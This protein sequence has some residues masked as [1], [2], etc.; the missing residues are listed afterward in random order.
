MPELAALPPGITPAT[1]DA[2]IAG[3]VGDA[4]TRRAAFARYE[5][6]PYHPAVSGRTW[7]HDLAKLDLSAVR[8]LPVRPQVSGATDRVRIVALDE[9]S[10]V[11]RDGLADL[12][13]FGALARAF[14]TGGVYVR[15][16]DGVRV[17]EPI[18][19]AYDVEGGAFPY[20]VVEVGD[21]AEVTVVEQLRG[22]AAG[23]VCGATEIVAG[24]RARVTHVVV[25]ELPPS[26]KAIFTRR[27]RAHADAHVGWALAELGAA[28]AV[29]D[30]RTRLLAPGAQAELAALF[31]ATG[32]QHVDLTTEIVHAA[33]HT[34]SQTIVKSAA[35]D[36]G[37]GRYVG[38]IGIVAHAHGSDASLRD[39]VLLLS[40]GAH[41]DSIPALEIAAN[42]VKAFHGATVGAIDEGELFY[43]QSRGIDRAQAEKMIALGFFEPVIA[44]FPTDA[45]RERL[46]AALESK[47]A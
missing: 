16:P 3:G 15:V 47:L 32:T 44:R 38:N 33:G 14:C 28:L 27:A 45:L 41:V 7:K 46:R 30:V 23:F 37:Q 21:G 42:D 29:D 8:A 1:L 25:Q 12:T 10:E 2:L 36:R 26:A 17:E 39:D 31:F 19:V 20:T 22:A 34:T 18:V 43:A 24:A 11:L 9:A 6:M 4:D 35:R 40:K 13:K 5:A